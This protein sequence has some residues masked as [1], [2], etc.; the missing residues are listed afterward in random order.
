MKS[1]F[2]K[3]NGIKKEEKQMNLKLF[4]KGNIDIH[5]GLLALLFFLQLL[6]YFLFTK[7]FLPSFV[8]RLFKCH[9]I[10]MNRQ[11]TRQLVLRKTHLKLKHKHAILA[12]PLC[13]D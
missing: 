11:F 7:I 10:I 13:R 8:S 5:F 9:Y 2:E 6:L 4:N 3:L 1:K 12:L